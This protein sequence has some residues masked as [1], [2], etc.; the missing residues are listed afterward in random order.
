[1]KAMDMP[2]TAGCI[3][4]LGGPEALT[5][6]DILQTIAHAA[7]TAKWMLP[8]PVLLLKGIA[9]ML[10]QYAFFPI[11][12]DSDAGSGRVPAGLNKKYAPKP[13]GMF[14]KTPA[15][16]HPNTAQTQPLI[17]L[18]FTEVRV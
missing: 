13:R 16:V 5:C 2:E 3:F 6:K 18:Q 4:S 17:P 1:M 9:A 14:A 10:D 7:G 11:T 15:S 8:A 12:R